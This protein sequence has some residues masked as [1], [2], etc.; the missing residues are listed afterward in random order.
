MP[1]SMVGLLAAAGAA[2]SVSAVLAHNDVF[3]LIIAAVAGAATGLAACL[4]L[5]AGSAQ[6]QVKK[7]FW[8][9]TTCHQ[10]RDR[11]P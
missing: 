3:L 9:V 2:M 5:P 4:A 8:K 11:A 7:K 6:R 10:P 1:R